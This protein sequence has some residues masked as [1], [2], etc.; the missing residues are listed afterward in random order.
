[1]DPHVAVAGEAC[2]TRFGGL[3]SGQCRPA[4]P[5]QTV[6]WRRWLLN[7][8]RENNAMG[9]EGESSQMPQHEPGIS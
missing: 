3:V 9:S 1:M 5:S 8:C 6:A 2:A 7:Q 4:R